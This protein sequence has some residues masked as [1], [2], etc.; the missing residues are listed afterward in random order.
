[1]LRILICFTVWILLITLH[2]G[3]WPNVVTKLLVSVHGRVI[4]CFSMMLYKHPRLCNVFRSY[5]LANWSSTYYSFHTKFP[6][7]YTL[8]FDLG[9]SA[10]AHTVSPR[11]LAANT[12][13][14]SAGRDGCDISG[15]GQGRARAVR[16]PCGATNFSINPLKN[17]INR[18]YV[19]FLPHG[20]HRG[21]HYRDGTAS[22]VLNNGLCVLWESHLTH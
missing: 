14:P 16:L 18:Q 20:K 22:V 4:R 15:N 21:L 5:Q 2:S 17:E 10:T 1:M 19:Y 13:L 3:C 7:V 11:I 8:E 12:Q 6:G 9:P